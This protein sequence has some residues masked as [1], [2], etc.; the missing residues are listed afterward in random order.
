[1]ETPGFIDL[2]FDTY[3]K[4]PYPQFGLET[5]TR[6]SL[7]YALKDQMTRRGVYFEIR[8]LSPIRGWAGGNIKDQ[9]IKRLVPLFQFGRIKIRKDLTDLIQ[10]LLTIPSARS[11]DIVDALSYIMDM[12]PPGMGS[13][14]I[15][16]PKR[17]IGWTRTGI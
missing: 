15:V 11:W 2:C 1:V 7:S 10:A 17:T 12:V 13:G 4:Y 6:K 3:G 9:R 5:N 8:D 14:T 16:L